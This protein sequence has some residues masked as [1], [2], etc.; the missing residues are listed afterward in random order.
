LVSSAQPPSAT[1]DCCIDKMR[2]AQ[3]KKDLNKDI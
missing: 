3:R 1:A 2:A